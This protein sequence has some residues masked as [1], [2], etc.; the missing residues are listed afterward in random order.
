VE[1][2]G[3]DGKR[4]HVERRVNEAGAAVVR[5]IFELCADGA[6]L[7]R[8]TKTLN[9]VGCPAPRSQQ[10]R[11]RAWTTSTVR[12]VLQ[13]ELYRGVIV[14]NQTR[15]RIAG[16]NIDSSHARRL[17]GGARLPQQAG[18]RVGTAGRSRLQELERHPALE[19]RILPQVH[20]AHPAGSEWLMIR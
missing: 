12:D 10:G 4:S 17:T 18:C 5:Q 2:L 7:T 15:K 14:W 19:V 3:P 9:E 11:P 6:R 8:I 20:R 16:D 13:R 1:V